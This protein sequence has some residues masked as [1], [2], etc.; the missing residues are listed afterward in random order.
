[1]MKEPPSLP[2]RAPKPSLQNC[3]RMR[4]DAIHERCWRKIVFQHDNTSSIP[5]LQHNLSSRLKRAALASKIINHIF[6][7]SSIA[8]YIIGSQLLA[9]PQPTMTISDLSNRPDGANVEHHSTGWYFDFGIPAFSEAMT[10]VVPEK[11]DIQLRSGTVRISCKLWPC[12]LCQCNTSY[13]LICCPSL[14][15]LS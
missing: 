15:H 4:C 2:F 1:M 6:R 10:T 12:N 5:Q 7:L 9:H 14:I 11:D 3:D 8:P 13:R